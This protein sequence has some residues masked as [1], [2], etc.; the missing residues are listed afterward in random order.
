VRLAV[1][2]AL[3]SPDDPE[4]TRRV[5][6]ALTH[7][8]SDESAEVRDWATFA[9]GSQ[10]D[11]DT[12]AVRSTLMERLDDPSEAVRDE[13]LRGLVRRHDPR[14]VEVVRERLTQDRADAGLFEAARY[15]AHPRLFPVLQEW[16][17][18]LPG[19]G[20]VL[21]A[22]DACDPERQ[23]QRQ[24]LHQQLL[25]AV[26]RGLDERQPATVAVL[27]CER[28]SDEVLLSCGDLDQVWFV[29][30]LLADGDAQEAARRVVTT[31]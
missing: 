13:A 29:P 17:A 8:C 25:D 9:L 19:D 2:Q 18:A 27:F 16:I 24:A 1:A 14:I 22:L 12:G 23:G 5:A 10:V 21:D 30:A 7:L 3:S 31:R 20:D 4:L 28:L 26:Q 11:L 6:G 15:L